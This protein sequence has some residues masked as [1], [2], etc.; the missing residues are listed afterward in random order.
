M[1]D[2]ASTTPTAATSSAEVSAAE[3]ARL[4]RERREKKILEG[5]STRLNKITGMQG[6][7]SIPS[8]PVTTNASLRVNS[9]SVTDDPAEVDISTLPLAPSRTRTPLDGG[10]SSFPSGTGGAGGMA[11]LEDLLGARIGPTGAAGGSAPQFPFGNLPGMGGLG[12]GAEGGAG[13]DPMAML[14]ALLGGDKSIPG[15]P[16]IPG[17]GMGMGQEVK[18]VDPWG[19]YW[20]FAHWIISISIGIWA[21]MADTFTGTSIDRLESYTGVKPVFWYFITAQ[22][23]LQTARLFSERGGQALPG[24]K[25]AMLAG[26]LPAPFGGWLMTFARYRFIFTSGLRD[27]FWLVFVLGV[28]TWVKSW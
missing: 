21:V 5:G 9:A 7:H 14:T 8:D 10:F 19:G 22:L 16:P 11:S 20:R 28:G 2:D 4:R 26:Q 15:M 23:I 1:A 6:A 3:K 12:V 27:L 25:L 24:S 13:G 17:M 18:A